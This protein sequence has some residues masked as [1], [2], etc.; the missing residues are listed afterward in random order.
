MAR[1]FEERADIQTDSPTCSQECQRL[2]LTK[3]ASSGRHRNSSTSAGQ[4]YIDRDVYVKPHMEVFTE[5]H[6]LSLKT[7]VPGDPKNVLL[8]NQA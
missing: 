4:P 2:V 3:K 1:S 6:H 7:C 5:V 8:F